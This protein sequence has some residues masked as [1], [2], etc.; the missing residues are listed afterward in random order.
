MTA[1]GTYSNTRGAGTIFALLVFTIF[2]GFQLVTNAIPLAARFA[3]DAVAINSSSQTEVLVFGQPDGV[4]GNPDELVV[5]ACRRYPC[6]AQFDSV[7]FRIRDS[8]YLDVVSYVRHFQPHY[9]GELAGL[10][11][12]RKTPARSA[13]M[14]GG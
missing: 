5:Y 3:Y 4:E 11:C 9:P 14:D 2:F 7:E 1:E 12:Q 8:T 6:E 13:T 10:L